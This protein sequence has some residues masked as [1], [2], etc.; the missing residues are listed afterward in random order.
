M[1]RLLFYVIVLCLAIYLGVTLNKNSGYVLIA[2]H[3]WTIEMS[4]WFA[5]IAILAAY[6]FLH[7]IFRFIRIVIQSHGHLLRWYRQRKFIK[8]HTKTGGGLLALEESSWSEAENLLLSGAGHST[9]PIINYLGAARAAQEQNNLKKRDDYLETALKKANASEK[10]AVYL[11]WARLEIQEKNY[12]HAETILLAILSTH[13]CNASALRMLQLIYTLNKNTTALYKIFPLLKKSKAFNKHELLSSEKIL[14][15]ALFSEHKNDL[16]QLHKLWDDL[17]KE[18]KK[19]HDVLLTFLQHL[20]ELHDYAFSEN[21]LERTLDKNY[22]SD[23]VTLYSHIPS[24]RAEKQLNNIKKWLKKHSQDACIYVA[25]GRIA[26][27]NK[28]PVEAKQF[29]LD[30]TKLKETTQAY[31][32]LAKTYEQLGDQN[33]RWDAMQKALSTPGE[34]L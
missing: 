26:L 30:S 1:R 28:K 13:K 33:A 20:V 14:Y 12:A 29:L 31:R 17:E 19:D 34:T 6:F 25:A 22:H 8:A 7:F 16:H 32:L 23:F 15:L 2:Y 9:M 24:K 5:I 21:L 3:H 4:L 27:R 18:N 10:L 11:A